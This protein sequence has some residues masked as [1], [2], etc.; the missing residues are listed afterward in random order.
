MPSSV[1]KEETTEPNSFKEIN[2]YGSVYD[3]EMES[4]LNNWT[5]QF[6]FRLTEITQESTCVLIMN[7]PVVSCAN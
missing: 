3:L 1:R 7:H 5:I 4:Q 6:P 2:R